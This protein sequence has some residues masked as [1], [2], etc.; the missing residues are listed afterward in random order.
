MNAA[1]RIRQ[2]LLRR[3][4]PPKPGIWVQQMRD[5]TG[6]TRSVLCVVATG[7]ARFKLDGR[8]VAGLDQ[9][10]FLYDGQ[11]IVR[12]RIGGVLIAAIDAVGGMLV[13]LG[14]DHFMFAGGGLTRID[15]RAHTFMLGLRGALGI[16]AANERTGVQRPTSITV[17]PTTNAPGGAS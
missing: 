12:H 5:S 2:K 10:L 8:A 11:R 15:R 14:A 7:K 3:V 4:A 1:Q 9:R 6:F 13:Q 16:D 17:H